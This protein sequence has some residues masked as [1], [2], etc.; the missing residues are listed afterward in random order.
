MV[1]DVPRMNY[2]YK[3]AT[4][5]DL[6]KTGSKGNTLYG[7]LTEDKNVQG[8]RTYWQAD[9][10]QYDLIVFSDIFEQCDLFNFIYKCYYPKQ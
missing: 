10:D 5:E 9:I 1:V 3:D 6:Y 4:Y 8:R 7:L 2:M